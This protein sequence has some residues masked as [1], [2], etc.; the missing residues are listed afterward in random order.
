MLEVAGEGGRATR[1]FRNVGKEFPRAA[2]D[3][4]LLA[5]LHENG[6]RIAA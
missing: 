3:A 4:R 1:M 6:V 5:L 2:A